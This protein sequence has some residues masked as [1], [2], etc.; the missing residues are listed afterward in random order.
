MSPGRRAVMTY[1][2]LHD[3]CAALARSEFESLTFGGNIH[4]QHGEAGAGANIAGFEKVAESMIA[5][6]IAY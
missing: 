1:W 4:R 2:L 6:G 3:V 5:Q